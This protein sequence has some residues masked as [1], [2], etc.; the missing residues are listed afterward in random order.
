MFA[1]GKSE[2][3][4]D[5]TAQRRGYAPSWLTLVLSQRKADHQGLESSGSIATSQAVA[6][7]PVDEQGGSETAEKAQENE[8]DVIHG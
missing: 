1:D 8:D 7:E 3:E 5:A 6:F 4:P 2:G